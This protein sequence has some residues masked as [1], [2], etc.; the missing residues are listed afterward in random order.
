MK[1]IKVYLSFIS[2]LMSL[3]TIAQKNNGLKLGFNLSPSIVKLSGNDFIN[4]YHSPTVGFSVGASVEV[5][6]SNLFSLCSGL[7]YEK[8]GSVIKNI[9]LVFENNGELTKAKKVAINYN[10]TTLPILMRAHV[11][12]KKKFF[13]DAGTYFGYLLSQKTKTVFSGS[14]NVSNDNDLYKKLDFGLAYG[15]GYAKTISRNKTLGIELRNNMGL[16]NVSK[17]DVVN[18]G[19]IKT[20]AFLLMMEYSFNVTKKIKK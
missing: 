2:M 10:Y 3:S 17:T 14:T 20:N 11:G 9:D 8:K 19:K 12:K 15:I 7:S 13:I 18:N 16:M 1:N 6:L 5:K 4:E